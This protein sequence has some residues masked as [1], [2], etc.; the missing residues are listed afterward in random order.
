MIR[1]ADDLEALSQSAAA[2]F[3]AEA[4]KAGH[5][6]GRFA[7]ALSGGFTPRRTLALLARPPFRDQ[8]PWDRVHVFWGDE[9]C[10][11]LADPRSNAGWALKILL[12]QVPI[13]AAQVRPMACA[14]DPEAGARAYENLL[15]EF[16]G[17][18]PPRLDLVFLGLGGNGHIAS[19]F[20]GHTV[21]KEKER[22]VV[23]VSGPGLDLHRVTLTPVL[24]NRARLVAFLVAGRDKAWVL[25]EVLAGPRDPRRLPAQLI[26]PENGEVLWLVDREAAAL[27]PEGLPGLERSF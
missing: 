17:D 9:R 11:S 4:Q 22:W 19:L 25:R 14:Q 3:A 8:V 6:R 5:A 10:V 2:L 12:S 21:L 23:P 27:L 13:P 1:V 15:R 20:P 24:F 18:G 26:H 16:F 7:V